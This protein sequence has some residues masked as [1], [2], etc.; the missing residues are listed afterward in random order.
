MMVLRPEGLIPSTRR[1]LE[2]HGD[3]DIDSDEVWF[4]EAACTT[5]TDEASPI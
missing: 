2:L 4:D 1:K 5:R 3:Q